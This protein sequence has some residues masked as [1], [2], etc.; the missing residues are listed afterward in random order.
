MIHKKKI[1]AIAAVTR[2]IQSEQ[3]QRQVTSKAQ[4][5]PAVEITHDLPISAIPSAINLWGAG[6]RSQQMQMR[7]LMQ[8]KSFH[9]SKP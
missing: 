6:G 2:Y 4:E 1:A 8:M 9:R 7:N 5:A 3:E